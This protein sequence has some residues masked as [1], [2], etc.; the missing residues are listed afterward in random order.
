ME[1]PNGRMRARLA[2]P[3]WRA[4]IPRRSMV[5]GGTTYMVNPHSAT[6]RVAGV[7]TSRINP[8]IR[9]GRTE[10]THGSFD[11]SRGPLHDI[12]RGAHNAL[13]AKIGGNDG[14]PHSRE[15]VHLV[16]LFSTPCRP[17]TGSTRVPSATPADR[18]CILSGAAVSISI[19]G[20][21][22]NLPW[23][24]RQAAARE[25]GCWL[26]QWARPEG[27]PRWSTRIGRGIDDCAACHSF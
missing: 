16:H 8:T 10:Q 6:K 21:K 1:W 23:A 12:P 4:A 27:E 9:T 25:K 22:S 14:G 13:E 20:A 24:P 19:R 15:A 3:G 17:C 2:T 7:G 26:P 11:F 5:M 18:L